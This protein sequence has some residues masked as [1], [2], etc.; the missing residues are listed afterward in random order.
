MSEKQWCPACDAVT[1][2]VRSAFEDG[3]PCPHCGLSAAAAAELVEAKARGAEFALVVD[4]A[5]AVRRAEEAEAE[6][7]RLRELLDRARRVLA[8]AALIPPSSPG[9]AVRAE[10][11]G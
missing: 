4:T 11:A 6:S 9:G 3:R 10:R 5:R 2:N 8:E 1:S 7:R